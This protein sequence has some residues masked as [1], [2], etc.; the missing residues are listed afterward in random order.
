VLVRRHGVYVW[1]AT[2]EAA[3]TQAECY[4]YLFEAAVRMRAIGIDPGAVPARGSGTGIGAARSYEAQAQA[5]AQAH[6]EAACCGGGASASTPT[7]T[8]AAAAAAAA[9]ES[10]FTGSAGIAAL[11]ASFAAA[12][13]AAGPGAYTAAPPLP[14]PR[15]S[16]IDAVLLDIEGCTTSI[17]FVTDTL[18]PFAAKQVG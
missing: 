17:A 1:G 12:A 14:P 15:L 7:S 18:F 6:H 3:K 9:P 10:G 2:W 5:Q 13:A 11:N 4:H 8:T 16:S